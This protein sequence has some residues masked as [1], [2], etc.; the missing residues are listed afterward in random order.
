[1]SRIRGMR[2]LIVEDEP[3]VALMLEDMLMEAGA[4]VVG[5]AYTLA[6]ALAA[7]EAEAVDGAILDVNLNAEP[8]FAVA[9][10]LRRRGI[11]FIFATGYGQKGIA[12]SYVAEAALSKPYRAA[13]VIA[14]LEKAMKGGGD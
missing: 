1:M 4:S 12:E 2:I 11:P 3:L 5:P 7:A 13:D 8:S 14:A 6:Q 10:T 9:D